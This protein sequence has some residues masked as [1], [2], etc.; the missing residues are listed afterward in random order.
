MGGSVG[1]IIGSFDGGSGDDF[2][3]NGFASMGF[4]SATWVSDQWIGFTDQWLG[5]WV[6][7]PLLASTGLMVCVCVALLMV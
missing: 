2:F 5:W 3:F 7:W 6:W 4:K 1:L